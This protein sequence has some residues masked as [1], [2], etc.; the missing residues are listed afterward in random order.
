M[1]DHLDNLKRLWEIQKS[2]F[3]TAMTYSKTMLGLGYGGFFALWAGTKSHL[4]A[5]TVLWSAALI[6]ISL[7]LYVVFELTQTAVVSAAALAF[8]KAIYEDGESIA[9]KGYQLRS[10][11]NSVRLLS[12]WRYVF[13]GCT[14]IGL[15]GAV[16]LI[17]GLIRSAWHS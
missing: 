6:G 4:G 5:R 1:P 17:V 14:L 15:S 7:F 12:T 9:T 10:S 13:A 3:D 11:R 16:L 2:S 8:T